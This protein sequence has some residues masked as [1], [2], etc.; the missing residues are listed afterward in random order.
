M[1]KASICLDDARA[2]ITAWVAD[3]NLQRP[4]SALGLYDTN[5]YAAAFTATSHRLRNPD[6]LR[7]SPVAPFAPDVV[8][9]SHSKRLW[10]KIQRQ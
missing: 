9:T 5:A 3:F 7:R 6:Q 4:H 10:M 2:T 1:Q 8:N